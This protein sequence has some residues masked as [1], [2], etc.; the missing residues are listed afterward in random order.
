MEE[1]LQVAKLIRS[2]RRELRFVALGIEI[3][4]YPGGRARVANRP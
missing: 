1:L 3:V 4:K 2:V